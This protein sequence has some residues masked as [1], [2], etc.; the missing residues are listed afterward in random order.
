MA[1]VNF[2]RVS[3]RGG[4]PGCWLEEVPPVAVEVFK[5]GDGAVGFVPR[6]LEEFD[7]V[8]LH[9]AVVAVEVVGV[10]EEEDAAGGLLADEL[11]LV[12][13]GGS[14]EKEGGAG[15]VR[16]GDE[17]PSLRVGE[18]RVFEDL[19]AEGFGEESESFIVITY[20]EG[21][22]SDGLGHATGLSHGRG[23]AVFDAKLAC[24]WGLEGRTY[25]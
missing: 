3:C 17:K 5:D 20:E 9:A 24:L 11:L 18:G 22:V 2:D 25:N 1:Q 16:R 23:N 10:E 21:D 14:S 15:G 12:G 4:V 19:E 6:R 13:S 7:I 8:G